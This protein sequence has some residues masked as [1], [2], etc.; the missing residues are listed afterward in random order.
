MEALDGHGRMKIFFQFHPQRC[1][2]G[3]VLGAEDDRLQKVFHLDTPA[4][5]NVHG[6]ASSKKPF[7]DR[8]NIL[9]RK[10]AYQG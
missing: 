4:S 6:G 8:L 2:S 5:S 9:E 7:F 1:L 3:V 10:D